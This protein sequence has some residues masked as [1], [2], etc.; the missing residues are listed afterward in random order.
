MGVLPTIAH[1]MGIFDNACSRKVCKPQQTKN[2]SKRERLPKLIDWRSTMT[3]LQSSKT[4]YVNCACFLRGGQYICRP[5][6]LTL[7]IQILRRVP[8][9][10]NKNQNQR[11][12]ICKQWWPIVCKMPSE[13]YTKKDGFKSIWNI[14]DFSTAYRSHVKSKASANDFDPSMFYAVFVYAY[15]TINNNPGA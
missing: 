12:Q 4:F 2:S 5:H 6:N 3:T 8:S 13:Q 15:T 11:N 7:C 10:S 9:R 1:I 14:H